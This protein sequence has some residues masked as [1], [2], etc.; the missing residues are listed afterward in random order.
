M[1][2][3][4]I[5]N[6]GEDLTASQNNLL[7]LLDDSNRKAD[8]YTAL[9]I[10]N[11][12]KLPP[13]THASVNVAQASLQEKLIDYTNYYDQMIT[14]GYKVLIYGGEWDA[15]NNPGN[16]DFLKNMKKLSASFWSQAR[17]IYY[18][19]SSTDIYGVAGY[20][21]QDTTN[22][23]SFVTLPKSGHFAAGDQIQVSNWLLKDFMNEGL[24]QCYNPG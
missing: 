20:V 21:R 12:Y 10:E 13:Y 7:L 11:S 6:F 15:A 3:F 17:Q 23:F 16:M 4:D 22:K 8:I 24:L 19:K 14:E 18:L 1:N 5:R 9:H 2:S